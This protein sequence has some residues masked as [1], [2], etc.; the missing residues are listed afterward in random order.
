MPDSED[1][2]IL[3]AKAFEV[4]CSF[5]IFDFGTQLLSENVHIDELKNFAIFIGPLKKPL[6]SIFLNF[7]PI[8]V[9]LISL[10][11]VAGRSDS[12][13]FVTKRYI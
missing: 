11:W 4:F 12:K 3:R 5:F 2:R 6:G 13:N 10:F 1:F 9:I 8:F 7:R